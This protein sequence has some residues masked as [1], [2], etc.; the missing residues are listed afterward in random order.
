MDKHS[1]LSSLF[2]SDG[3]KKFFIKLTT[4]HINGAYKLHQ[5]IFGYY[6]MEPGLINGRNHYR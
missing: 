6:T 3:E 1:S 2:D 4:G 5:Y